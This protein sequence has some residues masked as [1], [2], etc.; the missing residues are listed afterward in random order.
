MDADD[1]VDM[2]AIQRQLLFQSGK[3]SGDVDGD[4][5]QQSG[6]VADPENAANHATHTHDD[7]DGDGDVDGD[8]GERKVDAAVR[9]ALII[10]GSGG[11]DGDHAASPPDTKAAYYGD[12]GRSQFHQRY[13]WVSRQ[14]NIALT[15]PGEKVCVRCPGACACL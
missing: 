13:Q 1:T 9:E 12:S 7:G 10:D 4:G 15:T 2:E 8:G 5:D 11:D 3:E 6:H 14:R